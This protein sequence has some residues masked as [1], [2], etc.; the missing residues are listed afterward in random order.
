MMMRTNFECS[1]Y[2]PMKIKEFEPINAN[3]LPTAR[4]R[5]RSRHDSSPGVGTAVLGAVCV[6]GVFGVLGLL[7]SFG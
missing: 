1:G 2:K 6:I 4:S 5:R 7:Y 3:P